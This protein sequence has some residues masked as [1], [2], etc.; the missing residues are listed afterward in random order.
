MPGHAPLI[1]YMNDE[2]CGS[3]ECIIRSFALYVNLRAAGRTVF[4]PTRVRR[5]AE[6]R[7]E[8]H[9]CNKARHAG[10]I[11]PGYGISVRLQR[12]DEVQTMMRRIYRSRSERLVGGVAGGVAIYLGIDP[13]FVRLGFLVLSLLNGFGALLYFLLWV[14]LPNEGN[15]SADARTQ[16]RENFDEMRETAEGFVERVRRSIQ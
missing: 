1:I 9:A 4:A 12:T 6:P 7:H 13:L 2:S 14:L 3:R 11:A 15:L 8:K 5:A 16:V 10:V